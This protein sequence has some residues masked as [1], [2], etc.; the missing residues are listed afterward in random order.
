VSRAFLSHCSRDSRQAV[1]VKKRL[2]KQ[3]SFLA[4]GLYVNLDRRTRF[5]LTKGGRR[6]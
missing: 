1:A 6:R 5:R 2:L 4:D 3:E